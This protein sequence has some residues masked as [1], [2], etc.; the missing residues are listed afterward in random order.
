MPKVKLGHQDVMKTT[1]RTMIAKV[2]ALLLITALAGVGC[3]STKPVAWNVSI[4]KTT[5]SAIE[6]DL[7]GVAGDTKPVWEGYDMER[8]WKE[9]DQMRADA[10]KLSQNLEY[11]KPWIVSRTNDLWKLWFDRYK[12]TDLLVLANLPGTNFPA[13]PADPRRRFLSLR[14]N[15]W[16][17]KG[18]TLEVE[19]Q[20]TLIHVLTK[21]RQ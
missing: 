1:Q 2:S 7:I 4:T 18:H 12:A 6:V 17:A 8:Y 9:G 3:R 10:K 20:D 5:H 15:A 11:Q 13:G 19:V 16:D 21:P 14:K